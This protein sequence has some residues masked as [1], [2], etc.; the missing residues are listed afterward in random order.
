MNAELIGAALLFGPAAVA[1]PLFLISD[2]R[3]RPHQRA[4]ARVLA[5]SAAERAKPD[6]DGPAPPGA[7]VSTPEQQ[8]TPAPAPAARG[9][10]PVIAIRSRRT[11]A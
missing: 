1:G 9:L 5:E 11:A 6:W 3:E 4:I 10:A 2:W 7:P 8:P